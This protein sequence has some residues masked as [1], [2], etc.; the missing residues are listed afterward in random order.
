MLYG[1]VGEMCGREEKVS[2]IWIRNKESVQVMAK[3][4]N[5]ANIMRR[6]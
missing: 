6:T 1:K 4:R 3:N 5:G 2:N